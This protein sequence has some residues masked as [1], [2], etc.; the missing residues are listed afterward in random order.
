MIKKP[1]FIT[2]QEGSGVSLRGIV[3][4]I[5]DDFPN[6]DMFIMEDTEYYFV[7]KFIYDDF[8]EVQEIAAAISY[9]LIQEGICEFT[10]TLN[11][12]E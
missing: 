11:C 9:L 4:L 5:L 10:T 1:A 8:V 2:V 6:T 12:D 7:I 3:S